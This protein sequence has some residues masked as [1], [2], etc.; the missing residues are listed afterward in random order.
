MSERDGGR[1][2]DGI[3]VL[4][5][6]NLLAAP[7]ATMFLGDFG[8]DVIKAE[9]PTRGDEL[10]RWGHR[11]GDV[12]LFFKVLNRNK[13]TITLDLKSPR[14]QELVRELAR[15]CDVVVESYRPG[16]LAR[17]GIGHEQLREVNPGI[18]TLHV[19]GF[20]Q[21]GPW[22]GRPGFGTLAEAFSGYAH[23][24]GFPDRPPLLPSFGLGD[25][26]TAIFAAF[27]IML[28]LYERDARGGTGQEIDLGLY[29]GLFTLLG[30]QVVDYD[31]LGIVQERNGS[32]L[33]FVAPRNTY[34]TADG[35]WIAIAGSTQ[36]TFE[37]IAHALERPD[38]A[39]DPRFA[40]NQSRIA[41]A[42]VLDAELQEAIG[43]FPLDELL[44]I[45]GRMGAPVGPVYDIAQIFEHEQFAAREN[46]VAVPDAELGELRMQNVVPRLSGT[47]GRIAHAGPRLGEFNAEVYGGLLG[48]GEAELASLRAD[49]VI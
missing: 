36:T 17:W 22:S 45:F 10:R 31:Q 43:R 7:M 16:T 20:G 26:S 23:I 4:D 41:H 49:A 38:L 47:P 34:E 6:S 37:R 39:E 48:L 35:V 33:P 46:V 29:E 2:L 19:S 28:A 25:T 3:R 18:V 12:G 40:D 27:A 24:T 30:P 44:E 13:R 1:P 42:E 14:G 9:H 11:K 8:A 15:Q 32:R 21:T 5:L